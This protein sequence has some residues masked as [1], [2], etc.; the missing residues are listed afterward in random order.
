MLQLRLYSRERGLDDSSLLFFEQLPSPVVC[1]ALTGSDSLLVYTYQNILYHFI[2][3]AT[4]EAVTLVQV[5][6][7][8][9][10]G[11]VRAP[12]RVRA[13]SWI[14]P[15]HQLRESPIS[16]NISVQPLIVYRRRRSGTGCCSC[17]RD[18][19]R[20]CQACAIAVLHRCWRRLEI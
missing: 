11:I 2:I 19:P 12:A 18:L 5:G 3:N 20:R 9:L 15:D 8:A 13:V 1:I 6:Q 10:N 7:I 17:L 4:F 16:P 14:L